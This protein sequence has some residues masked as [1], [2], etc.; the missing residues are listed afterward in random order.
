[1][2]SRPLDS[3][4]ES[5]GGRSAARERLLTD[6]TMCIWGVVADE[7]DGRGC[8]GDQVEFDLR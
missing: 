7:R 2:D 4:S 1:V 6:R 8:E 5:R 3:R